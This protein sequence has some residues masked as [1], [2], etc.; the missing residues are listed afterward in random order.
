[1]KL[2]DYETF[3]HMPAGTIFAPYTP[4]ILTGELSI[5][6]DAGKEIDGKYWFNGVMPLSPWFDSYTSLFEVGEEGEA[7]FEIY[8]G[9]NNDYRD[10]KTIL[11]FDETDVDR[12]IKVL[13]WAKGGCKGEYDEI[14][15][16]HDS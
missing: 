12:L 10:C 16:I 4:C 5:K 14:S 1:M 13:Q 15:D 2:V 9:D 3:I 7:Q 6:V 8:D 11:V